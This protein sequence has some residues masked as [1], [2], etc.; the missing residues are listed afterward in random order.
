MIS[1]CDYILKRLETA[2]NLTSQVEFVATENHPEYGPDLVT[3]NSIFHQGHISVRTCSRK[4]F[5]PFPRLLVILEALPEG[6]SPQTHFDSWF[7][8]EILNAIGGHSML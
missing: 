7:L 3:G 5:I 4:V 1:L 2:N 8:L 6:E